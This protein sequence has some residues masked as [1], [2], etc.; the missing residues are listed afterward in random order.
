VLGQF[1]G[2]AMDLGSHW[3]DNLLERGW[4][5]PDGI[6]GFERQVPGLYH[7]DRGPGDPTHSGDAALFT[8]AESGCCRTWSRIAASISGISRSATI[9]ASGQ[10]TI[11][12]V[13]RIVPKSGFLSIRPVLHRRQ[14]SRS[15]RGA[16]IQI[17]AP[18]M[19]E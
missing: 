11:A 4:R 8:A 9:G 1:L 12:R 10:S 7:A 3:H 17:S 19:K 13:S 15:M 2:D 16:L 14:R 18:R 5:Y 6:H